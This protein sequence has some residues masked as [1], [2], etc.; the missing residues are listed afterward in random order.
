MLLEGLN[1]NR[2]VASLDADPWPEGARVRLRVR[3][4]T[5][6]AMRMGTLTPAEPWTPWAPLGIYGGDGDA[7]RSEVGPDPAQIEVDVDTLK[8]PAGANALEA[9]LELTAGAASARVRRLA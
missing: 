6:A 2:V 8:L 7:P 5:P 9:S 4:R 1:A 3:A